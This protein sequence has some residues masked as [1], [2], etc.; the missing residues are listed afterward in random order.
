MESA[1]PEPQDTIVEIVEDSSAATFPEAEHT[2]TQFTRAATAAYRRPSLDFL[3]DTSEDSWNIFLSKCV[4]LHIHTLQG[5]WKAANEIFEE[6]PELKTA[7]IANG[8]PTVLHIAA[9]TNHIPFVEELLK[10]IDGDAMELQD[11]K[12][13][14]AFC[15]V[16]ASGNWRI[17]DLMLNKNPSLA[18]IPGGNGMFPV[19]FAA[20]QGR[21]PMACKLYPKTKEAFVDADRELLFFTCI[22]T[23]NYHLALKMVSDY[24]QLAFARDP[25]GNNGTALHLL[26][27]HQ[28][29]LDS[30]CRCQGHQNILVKTNPGMKHHIVLQLVNFL[31]TTITEKI[32]SRSKLIDII[33]EPSPL[34]FDA[35]K[36]G[37]VGFLSELISQYPSLIWEVDSE[38]RSIIHTAVLH[39]HAS[40]YNLVHEI[41]PIRDIIV[42][43]EEDGSKNTLLHLAAELAPRSQ[44]ELVSGAAFQM[45]AEIAWFKEVKKIMP[46]SLIWKKN[47]G[48]FTAEEFFTEKHENLRQKAE[49]WMKRTAEFCM[50]ISTVIA[51]GVFAAAINI[52]GGMNDQTKDPNYLNKKSFQLFAISN[53]ISLITSATAILIFLSILVSRYAEHDFHMKLPGKLIFGMITLFISISCMMVAFGS[54]FFV[55]YYHCSRVVPDLISVLAFIPIL[56]F[57]VL[58]RS[59]WSDLFR[60]ITDYYRRALF[61]PG[62]NIL[63]VKSKEGNVRT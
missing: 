59:L 49:G 62:K 25:D 57:I 8:W 18:H 21:C 20:L 5:N 33:N 10:I 11:Q 61:K 36:V 51:T 3:D 50:L 37:N 42:T 60:S 24:K 48:D 63:Y 29:P 17:A 14:T 30:C 22:K 7:A 43:F 55:T 41:G 23:H 46:A 40:I 31:W 35:V 53:A 9:G 19:H 34:L 12:G 45:S 58:Q 32:D 47:S 39:R 6:R 13:N 52:P 54:A 2:E 27:K 44:L 56:L 28:K 16:A 4:P 26:A 1:T 38:N 15:F